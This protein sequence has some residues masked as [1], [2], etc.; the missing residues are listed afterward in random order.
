MLH[1]NQDP[2]RFVSYYENQVGG[3][4]PGFYGTPMMYGRG[5]GSI[6][7]K[8]FRFVAPLLKTGFAAAKPHLKTAATNIATDAVSHVMGK[9]KERGKQEGAGGIMVLS[10]RTRKRPPG[11]RVSSYK[12]RRVSKRSRSVQGDGVKRR[13]SAQSSDIF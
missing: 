11:D 2:H 6:F 9:L 12:K 1:L 8:L 13:K 5:I 7:S 10:R 3:A 4:L